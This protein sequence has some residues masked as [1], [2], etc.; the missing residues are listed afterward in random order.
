MNVV[1]TGGSRG[2]GA[3]TA[4]RLAELGWNV[5]VIYKNDETAAAK[6]VQSIERLGSHACAIRADISVEQEVVDAFTQADDKLGLLSGLINNAG[7][8]AYSSRLV[9]MDASRIERTMAVNTVGTFLCSREAVRRMSYSRGGAGGVII[10]V[11]SGAAVTGAPGEL[12]DYAASK[13]AIEAMT[14]G[15]AKEVGGE[16]IRVNSVR[17]GIIDTEI[18]AKGGHPDRAALVAPTIPLGRCGTPEEVAAAICWLCSDEA[19]YVTGAV[20]SVSGGR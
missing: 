12:L 5:C 10:N 7:I 17:P 9:D 18:H 15:L 16:G 13:A 19:S 11:S 4:R 6:V 1:V 14:I 20:L 3:A 2:I 8:A